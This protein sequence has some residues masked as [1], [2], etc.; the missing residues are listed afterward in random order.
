MSCKLIVIMGLIVLSC[1]PMHSIHTGGR[2]G[3]DK[4]RHRWELLLSMWDDFM[5]N[6]KRTNPHPHHS[7]LFPKPPYWQN[8]SEKAAHDKALDM[9]GS[10]GSLPPWSLWK[11][12]LVDVEEDSLRSRFD[13]IDLEDSRISTRPPWV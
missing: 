6:D 10:D 1:L 5:E 2:E 8:C 9:R 11:G 3:G 7:T 4:D 12:N 13:Y